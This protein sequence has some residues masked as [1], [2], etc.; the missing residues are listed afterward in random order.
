M[1]TLAVSG[2]GTQQRYARS[3]IFK[4]RIKEY[5]GRRGYMHSGKGPAVATKRERLRRKHYP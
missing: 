2:I 1:R 5:F 3:V 4:V